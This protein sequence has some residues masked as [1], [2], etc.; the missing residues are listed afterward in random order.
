MKKK[1]SRRLTIIFIGLA[2]IPLIIVGILLAQ[3]NYAIIAGQAVGVQSEVAQ[4]VAKDV[5]DFISTHE[6][7]LLV[8][9]N[10][11]NVLLQDREEQLLALTGLMASKNTYQELA[12][13]DPNGQEVVRVGTIRA[14]TDDELQS[15]AGMPEFEAARAS[16]QIY[17][18]PVQFDEATGESYLIIAVPSFDVQTGQ[19]AGVLVANIFFNPVWDMMSGVRTAGD[20]IV[21]VV[22]GENRV[23]AH[24]DPGIVLQGA[25]FAP[26]AE[27]GFTVGLS[28]EEA[29]VATSMIHFG[30]QEFYT[31]AELGRT[32]ALSLAI[33]TSM[34]IGF[35]FIASLLVAIVI[36]VIIARQIRRMSLETPEVMRM[37]TDSA[38]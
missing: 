21:Y 15:R 19:F 23:V 26:P 20:G 25:Q 16:G 8:L 29:A 5:R 4:R 36:S 12:V 33:S 32:E 6:K 2:T 10:I 11:R 31:V 38:V 24:R 18:S 22:D 34:I 7:E 13:L 37:A 27:D 28:G 17:Y 3:R 30:Q 35:V 9:T 14:F 1:L